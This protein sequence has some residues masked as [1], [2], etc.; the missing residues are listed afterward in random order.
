VSSYTASVSDVKLSSTGLT[1]PGGSQE[2]EYC[3]GEQETA[4]AKFFFGKQFVKEEKHC[5]ASKGKSRRNPKKKRRFYL[6]NWFLSPY[7]ISQIKKKSHLKFILLVE[8]MLRNQAGQNTQTEQ[9]NSKN[10]L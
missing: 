4:H 1:Q 3:I 7:T 9:F 10:V 2:A 6:S 5:F 8:V